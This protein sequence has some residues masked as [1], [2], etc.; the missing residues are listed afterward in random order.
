MLQHEREVRE[1][2]GNR[3]LETM[4]KRRDQLLQK[5]CAAPLTEDEMAELDRLVATIAA[6]KPDVIDIV[7]FAMA[8]VNAHAK[9]V[10][11]APTQLKT[12]LGQNPD[13]Q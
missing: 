3:E 13:D 5:P 6:T 11:S 12:P 10:S 7:A 4:V 9:N 8:G 2:T 1:M